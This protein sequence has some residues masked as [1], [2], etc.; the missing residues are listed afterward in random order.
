MG[1]R[2]VF[3]RLLAAMGAAASLANDSPSA[4]MGRQIAAGVHP[5]EAI[6]R[7]VTRVNQRQRRKR[8]RQLTR[9]AR[10]RY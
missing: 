7:E 8:F 1:L 9:A 2:N 4:R 10:R 3:V 5:S 6:R